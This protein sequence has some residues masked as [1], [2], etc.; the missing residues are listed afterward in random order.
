MCVLCVCVCGVCVCVVCACVYI[1]CVCI[2]CV[3]VWSFKIPLHPI[4][5]PLTTFRTSARGLTNAL[6]SC[7]KECLS[8]DSL[9]DVL[10]QLPLGLPYSIPK[11][12]SHNH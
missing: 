2:L 8:G 6:Q 7:S 4:L 5:G 11:Q 9:T 1:V 3:C 12:T 10:R